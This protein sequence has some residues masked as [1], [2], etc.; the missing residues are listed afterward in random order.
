MSPGGK[1][2]ES[3]CTVYVSCWETCS[4]YL[5]LGLKHSGLTILRGP[6]PICYTI[7][8]H[9][10][11]CQTERIHCYTLSWNST[12]KKG[13]GLAERNNHSLLAPLHFSLLRSPPLSILI[14]PNVLQ[15]NVKRIHCSTCLLPWISQDLESLQL[16]IPSGILQ[17]TYT[18][19]FYSTFE[20][21]FFQN[22]KSFQFSKFINTSLAESQKIDPPTRLARFFFT[23]FVQT[24]SSV[25]LSTS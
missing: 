16:K 10:L 17:Y 4:E 15:C 23:H 1:L 14:P 7:Q 19:V 9:V 22:K 21:F 11:L 8:W 6:W 12:L 3:I 24:L 5:V 2:C 18:T 13:G 20:E 25:A